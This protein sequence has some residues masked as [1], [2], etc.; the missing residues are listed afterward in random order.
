M[1]LKPQSPTST[2][3][4]MSQLNNGTNNPQ[5]VTAQSRPVRPSKEGAPALP[6]WLPSGK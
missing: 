3:E 2:G 6:T 4:V 1:N 5:S